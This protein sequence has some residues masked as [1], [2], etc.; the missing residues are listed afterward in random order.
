[1]PALVDRRFRSYFQHNNDGSIREFSS[2]TCVHGNEIIIKQPGHEQGINWDFCMRCMG[3]ICLKC[4]RTMARTGECEAFE[5]A[6]LKMERLQNIFPPGAKHVD[7]DIARL[8]NIR[9]PAA[10]PRG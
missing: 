2:T 9:E 3:P 8:I 7:R 4:A 10:E 1:M 6:L 5:K